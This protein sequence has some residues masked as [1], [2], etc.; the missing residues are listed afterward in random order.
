MIVQKIKRK[1]KKGGAPQITIKQ[2]VAKL[3][4]QMEQQSIFDSYGQ[5]AAE[6]IADPGPPHEERENHADDVPEGAGRDDEIVVKTSDKF[7]EMLANRNNDDFWEQQK[8]NIRDFSEIESDYGSVKQWGPKITLEEAAGKPVL[9][10]GFKI[11]PSVKKQGTDC[12]TMLLELEDTRQK[13]VLFTGSTVLMKLCARHD[14]AVPFRTRI[15]K[16]KNYYAF[17]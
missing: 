1:R 14:K 3:A 5:V 2:K 7:A 6:T 17:G 9:F 10:W 13:V 11:A 4:E 12:L 15:S 8:Q 16:I